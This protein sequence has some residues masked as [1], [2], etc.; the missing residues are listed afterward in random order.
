VQFGFDLAGVTNANNITRAKP[1]HRLAFNSG[2][3]R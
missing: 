3:D 1:S 2:A